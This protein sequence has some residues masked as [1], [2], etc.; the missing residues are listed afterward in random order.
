MSIQVG[1]IS[2]M[3]FNYTENGGMKAF[4]GNPKHQY[5]VSQCGEHD[6][7]ANNKNNGDNYEYPRLP[8]FTDEL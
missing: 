8:Y 5:R 4:L 2:R 1:L 6:Y 7:D 3:N